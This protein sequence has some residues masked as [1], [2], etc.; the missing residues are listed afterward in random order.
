MNKTIAEH[1]DP[2]TNIFKQPGFKEGFDGVGEIIKKT[3]MFLVDQLEDY[4]FTANFDNESSFADF[5]DEF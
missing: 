4:I 5:Y 1:T 3:S 2:K